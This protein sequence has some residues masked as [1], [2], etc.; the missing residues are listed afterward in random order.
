MKTN[1]LSNSQHTVAIYLHGEA[2]SPT[3]ITALLESRPTLQ[4]SKGDQS[5][6]S[7]GHLIERASGLWCLRWQDHSQDYEK[8]I[9]EAINFL[10]AR[11]VCLSHIDGVDR[12]VLSIFVGI[13]REVENSTIRIEF[14]TSIMKLLEKHGLSLEIESFC[15]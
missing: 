11:D 6:T 8:S 9:E 4:W 7:T 13:S 2:L 10:K 1:G 14:T 15:E 3:F 12:A 5:I